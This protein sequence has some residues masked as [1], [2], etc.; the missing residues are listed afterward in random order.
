MVRGRV[1][2]KPTN[3]TATTKSYKHF[4]R[5]KENKEKSSLPQNDKWSIRCCLVMRFYI[6][7][8]SQSANQCAAKQSGRHS[9]SHSF[10][11]YREQA[12]RFRLQYLRYKRD[13]KVVAWVANNTT[14]MVFVAL[15][16]FYSQLVCVC[17]CESCKRCVTWYTYRQTYRSI[18]HNKGMQFPCDKWF[19]VRCCIFF[20]K[21]RTNENWVL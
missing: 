14:M 1:T 19:Q 18:W 3:T 7:S 5:W 2:S 12:Q 13:L 17:M 16:F 21:I 20:Q 8:N 6:H 9:V 10:I 4:F 15:L 11:S